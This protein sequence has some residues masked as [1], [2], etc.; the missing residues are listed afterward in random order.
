MTE[1]TDR[2]FLRG[3]SDGG[4]WDK[5]GAPTGADAWKP[6]DLGQGVYML[7]VDSGNPGGTLGMLVGD[8]GALLI[9][10]GLQ[11]AVD[12][13]L[14]TTEN[15][16]GGPVNY[17]IT[18]HL[19]GDHVGCNANYA[20][21]GTTIISHQATREALL[22]DDTF[23]Q[24]GLPVLTFKDT[25]SLHLNGQ[26]VELIHYPNAHTVS[27]TI[28]HFVEANVIHAADLFFNKI[29]PFI[30]LENG[31][32]IDGFLAAQR[33][34][35]DLANDETKIIAGHGPMGSKADMQ[36]AVSLMEGIREAMEPLV[37]RGMT[38]EDV[39]KE[40]PLAPFEKFSWFH[41]T[42]ERM[43]KIVYFLLKEG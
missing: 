36:A 39:L 24:A 12:V 31:G 8:E 23:D 33:K 22:N 11:K 1:T 13:T 38:L 21:A 25:A 28:V 27:D 14:S 6:V 9:D 7:E 2:S 16:A 40:N 32:S 43:T 42:T 34:V 37:S 4:V 10:T 3:H 18:T 17:L 19:H 41:I 35:I 26:T 15:L 5:A 29:Y 30:D 20:A